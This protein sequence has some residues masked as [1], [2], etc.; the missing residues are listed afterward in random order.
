ME[1]VPADLSPSERYKLLIGCI[2]PRPIAF[3]ST[4]SVD[5]RPNLAPFSFFNGVGSDPMT[6][7]FCPA[8]RPDGG[9]K[10]TLRNCKPTAEGGTGVFVVN[11]AVEAYA[12]QMAGAAEPLACGDSEFEL[13]GLTPAPSVCVKAPRV[14]ESPV[15]FEC[16]TVHIYRT[17]A[18]VA[19]G[20]N[21]VFGRVVHVYVRDDLLDGRM[22][23]DPDLLAAIGRMGEQ[24]YARTR[25]RFELP[26][27][28]LGLDPGKPT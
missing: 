6:V 8:N 19:G 23:V 17:N 14:A 3:V 21:A 9:E 11:A 16:E 13:V 12:R 27:G 1:L 28:Q 4:V 26:R 24:S 25:D 5:G 22:R 18:G 20:G 2:V 15:C 7:V 10:D